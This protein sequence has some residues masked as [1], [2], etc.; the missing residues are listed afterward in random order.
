MSYE[1]FNRVVIHSPSKALIKALLFEYL[2]KAGYLNY[3]R[4]M[5]ASLFKR[6][7]WDKMT[8]DCKLYCQHFVI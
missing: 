5:M 7:W 3:R 2:K 6:F 4:L 1:N 8:L